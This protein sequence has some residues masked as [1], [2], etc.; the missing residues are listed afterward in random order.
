[1]YEE[2]LEVYLEMKVRAYDQ[3]EIWAAFAWMKNYLWASE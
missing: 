3:R 1:M 2:E